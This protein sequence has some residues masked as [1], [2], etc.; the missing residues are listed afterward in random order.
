MDKFLNYM[1]LNEEDDYD[2][3]YEEEYEP[4]EK[5]RKSV[6]K[7]LYFFVKRLA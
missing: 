5:S 3:E 6:T 7:D 4:V 2:D 1:K